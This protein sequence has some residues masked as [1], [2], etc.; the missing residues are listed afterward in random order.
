VLVAGTA[1]ALDAPVVT[2]NVDD[3]AHFGGVDV[4]SY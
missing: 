4:E 3:F 1:R 2:R